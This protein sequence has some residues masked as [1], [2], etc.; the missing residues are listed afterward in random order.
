MV[1]SVLEDKLDV[2]YFDT[3]TDISAINAKLL[4]LL[5]VSIKIL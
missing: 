3:R 4:L 1:V 2:F 5:L